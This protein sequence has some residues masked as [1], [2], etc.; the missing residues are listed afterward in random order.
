MNKIIYVILCSLLLSFSVIVQSTQYIYPV[1]FLNN[2]LYCIHQKSL[3]DINLIEYNT[4]KS[5]KNFALS[6]SFNPTNVTLLP[7]KNGISFIDN[8]VIKIKLFDRRSP[9]NIEITEPLYNIRSIYWINNCGLINA[10]YDKQFGIFIL[11]YEGNV[12]N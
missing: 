6:A 4:K 10:Q 7:Q 5:T 9:K 2:I 3:Y 1:F 12:K 11:D 8:G